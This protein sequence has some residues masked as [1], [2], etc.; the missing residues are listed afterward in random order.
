[1]GARRKPA[2]GRARK[3]PKVKK[4]RG[5]WSRVF[6]LFAFVAVLGV[7]S[8]LWV[9]YQEARRLGL[10]DQGSRRAEVALPQASNPSEEIQEHERAVLEEIIKEQEGNQGVGKSP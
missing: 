3:T 5:L 2:P 9:V 6:F 7:L 10:L 4:S 1:M 8:A